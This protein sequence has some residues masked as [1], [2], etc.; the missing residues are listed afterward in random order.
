MASIVLVQYP[1]LTSRTTLS[2]FCGK[3]HMAL[4]LKGLDYE[5]RNVH[6]PSTV[7]R[8][9]P[10]GR[11]P[12]LLVDGRTVVDSSDIL[13]ELD[14][15]RPEPPLLPADPAQRAACRVIEDWADEMLYFL[16]LYLRWC[17]DENF[18]RMRREVLARLPIPVR[19]IAPSLARR[20]TRG[21]ARAQG[22]GLKPRETVERE[23]DGA[24]AAIEGLLGATPFL[25][26]RSVSRADVAVAAV[27]DQ[28]ALAQLTPWAARRIGSRPG[29]EA[30]RARVAAVAGNAATP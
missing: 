26:G 4:R 9:N 7:K 2:P 15:L 16:G 8:Y 14:R 12:V 24:L 5:V 19:W 10:R 29:L 6:L 23:F 17:I 25:L 11:V 20:T 13:D 27:L 21:R 28:L 3:V 30:W 22:V 18:A 1:G